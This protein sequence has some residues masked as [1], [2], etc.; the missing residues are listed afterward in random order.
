MINLRLGVTVLA[1]LA[2]NVAFSAS[3]TLRPLQINVGDDIRQ[4]K[5]EFNA[6][7]VPAVT[8]INSSGSKKIAIAP[9]GGSKVTPFKELDLDGL[10]IIDWLKP[11]TN[12]Q[13]EKSFS[14]DRETLTKVVREGLSGGSMSSTSTA[15]TSLSAQILA[16]LKLELGANNIR[17]SYWLLQEDVLKLTEAGIQVDQNLWSEGVVGKEDAIVATF[18]S[19]QVDGKNKELVML[20]HIFTA[21]ED[22]T[23]NPVP[24]K[25]L[26]DLAE[27][28]YNWLYLSA[29]GVAFFSKKLDN[30]LQGASKT[31][32]GLLSPGSGVILD[33]PRLGAYNACDQVYDGISFMCG[34]S[35][36]EG[37]GL[38]EI[39]NIEISRNVFGYSGLAPGDVVKVYKTTG[40]RTLPEKVRGS[41][42]FDLSKFT[43][44]GESL[45]VVFQ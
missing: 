20:S 1:T 5:E 18:F 21:D 42:I 39:A 41:N 8:D 24:L 26:Q 9:M 38:D 25:H 4:A 34:R 19:F 3:A 22:L 10:V 14:A 23:R 31:F 11:G 45:E 13:I 44:I 43:E 35:G 17:V 37:Y 28:Q 40:T 15:D 6:D 7:L 30:G 12:S 27:G 2:C 29:D 33:Y 36:L 16:R 32:L